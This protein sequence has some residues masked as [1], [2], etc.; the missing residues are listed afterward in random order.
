MTMKGGAMTISVVP[1]AL[2]EERF[3]PDWNRAQGDASNRHGPACC[4]GYL[5]RH[6][7]EQEAWTSRAITERVDRMFPVSLKTL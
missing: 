5:P 3:D 1:G 7:L 2:P 4:P 6:V